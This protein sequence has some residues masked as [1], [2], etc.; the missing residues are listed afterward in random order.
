MD[1]N[2]RYGSLNPTAEKVLPWITV[3]RR[4][5]KRMK[6][7]AKTGLSKTEAAAVMEKLQQPNPGGKWIITTD[8]KHVV[9]Y[10]SW[11]RKATIDARLGPSSKVSTIA[12]TSFRTGPDTFM[13]VVYTDEFSDEADK[14]RIKTELLRL[15]IDSPLTY[16]TND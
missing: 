4:E 15:G 11:I 7:P 12:P 3:I 9:L 1:H 8:A 13:I 6:A 16:R 14:A 2:T 10:W 5:S